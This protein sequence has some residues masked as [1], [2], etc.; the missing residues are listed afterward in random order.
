MCIPAALQGFHP[1][2]CVVCLTNGEKWQGLRQAQLVRM[3]GRSRE[4]PCN[5]SSPVVSMIC[6]DPASPQTDTAQLSP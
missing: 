2:F 3:P 1:L 5:V 6:C 4:L